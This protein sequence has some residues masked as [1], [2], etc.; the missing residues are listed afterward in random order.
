MIS[1]IKINSVAGVEAL[2]LTPARGLTVIE[3]GNGTGKTS[4]LEAIRTLGGGHD[5]TLLRQGAEKGEVVVVFED[6]STV[7]RKVGRTSSPVELVAADGQRVP[8]P[9]GVLDRI[10]DALALNPVAFLL[11]P[12]KKRTQYLL[13]MVQV[14]VTVDE[15]SK[16]IGVPYNPGRDFDGSNGFEVL[17]GLAR[18]FANERTGVNRAAKEK[19]ITIAQLEQSLPPEVSQ[20]ESPDFLRER[21]RR[22][23]DDE[24]AQLLAV[25]ETTR[26]QKGE[27]QAR[28][29]DKVARLQEQI[30]QARADAA[31]EE[32][33]LTAKA[34]QTEIDV[35]RRHAQP[36]A[37]LASRLAT[38]EERQ[39]QA[40]RAAGA[41][42]TITKLKGE[43]LELERQTQ[44]TAAALDG[45]GALRLE[46]L[47]RLPVEG[48]EIREGELYLDGLPFDRTNTARR[49][50]V[51]LMLAAQR[52]GELG[53]VCV[54]GLECL[55]SQSW[56]AFLKAAPE[57]GL[58]LIVTRV[59]E[60]PLSVRKFEAAD[61]AEVA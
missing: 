44:V 4:I 14:G 51:A 54:D 39:R 7:T 30:S 5:A 61:A 38:S 29:Q 42:D 33:E 53:L 1:L 40:Q 49:V 22:E 10:V 52:A 48:L 3:G 8:K 13:E 35:K 20:E 47:K 21:Q 36:L 15:I 26:S 16:S 17:D 32:R 19:R 59:T 50:K 31:Q 43:V 46:L 12:P 57:S 45:I 28:L 2:E 34:A 6:G 9:Q 25:Q 24:T 37:D 27:V 18:D 11:A 23:K 55:D 60:G 56:E 58:Q 41:R